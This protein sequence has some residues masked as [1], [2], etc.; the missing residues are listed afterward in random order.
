MSQFEESKVDMSVAEDTQRSIMSATTAARMMETPDQKTKT[1][2]SG[3][4]K[5][6]ISTT[7]K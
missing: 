2:S 4:S 1:G 5:R 6:K 3:R 7:I